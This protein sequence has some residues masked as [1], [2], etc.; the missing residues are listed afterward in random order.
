MRTPRL[1]A[2]A[3]IPVALA[4]IGADTPRWT[5]AQRRHWSFLPPKRPTT[6]KVA[7]AADARNPVDAFLLR[8]LE[9][10]GLAFAPE[11]DRPTLLRRLRYD[12]TGLPPTPE[13]LAAFL[14]DD[15]PDAYERLVDR[16][17]ADP[18]FGER[19]ARPWLDLARYAESD[20]FKSDLTRPDAWRYRDWVVQA[21]NADMPYDRFVRLQLAGD[22][23]EPGSADAFVATGFNRG[24]PYE[25]NNKI[26]GQNRQIM[27][28]DVAD[29]TAGV[30]LGLTVGCARCHDHKY[31]PISQADYY[32]FQ[33]LFAGVAAKDDRPLASPF[34][35]AVGEFVR[36][37]H[38]AKLDAAKREVQA[39]ERPYLATV[40]KGKM[41]A[42]PA[43][44]RQALETEPEKRSAFQ[45]DLLRANAAKLAADPKAMGKAMSPEDR[46]VWER[47]TQSMAAVAK[48]AP[49]GLPVAAGMAERGP[50]APPTFMF[51]KGNFARPTDRVEPGFPSVLDPAGTTPGAPTTASTGRRLALAAWLTRPDHPLTARVQANRLWQVHFG[52]GLVA[53]PSDFGTQGAPP[54]HPELLDWLAAELS[55]GWSQKAIHRLLV[56]S[57]AYRQQ[58]TPTAAALAADPDNELFGRMPRRRL[59][60]EAVRDGLLAASGRLDR[61]VGGPSVFPD[62]PPGVQTR[63]G[64]TRSEKAADRDRRSLYIFVR[65][66]LKYPLLDAFDA[67][68]TNLTCSERNTSVNAPQALMLLNSELVLDLARSF[69][70]T[71]KRESPGGN[72]SMMVDRAY[73]RA[74]ARPPESAEREA[75]LSFLAAGGDDALAD[76]CHALLNLNEFVFVD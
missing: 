61:R 9:A 18:A 69:A 40:L 6:P 64:W 2:L 33:A 51:A 73:R 62:L 49:P 46:A 55:A 43:D 54:S 59:E 7:H 19:Q 3:L 8:E 26:P 39:V 20:G 23:A 36:A 35:V 68:D 52:R 74:F 48:A 5:D 1:A 10:N 13:E 76:Y 66:N 15:R 70:A 21:M 28:D 29:T 14:A 58:S 25:D 53:T 63:G 38:K 12:L 56:T 4:A 75:G 47:R 24:W 30:F 16:L 60:A 50:V 41:A 72:P 11:A 31:D 65:R 44:V 57:T 45:E 32:R 67:P 22:E 37:S 71:V 17:L 42:L 27:L 34:E